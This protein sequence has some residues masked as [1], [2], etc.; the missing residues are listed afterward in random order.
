MGDWMADLDEARRRTNAR[1]GATS[2]RVRE[3]AD[4]AADSSS[5]LVGFVLCGFSGAI[6]GFLVGRFGASVVASVLR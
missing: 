4:V 3:Q 1:I 2:A 5:A 6:F